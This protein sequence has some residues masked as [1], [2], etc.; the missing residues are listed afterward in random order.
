MSNINLIIDFGDEMQKS[1][2]LWCLTISISLPLNGAAQVGWGSWLTNLFYKAQNAVVAQYRRAPKTTAAVG[3]AGIAGLAG[4]V[5]AGN[6]L[7]KRYY[8]NK[9]ALM[10]AQQEKQ[11]LIEET[12][13]TRTPEEGKAVINEETLMQLQQEKQSLIGEILAARTP[14]EAEVVLQKVDQAFA[15]V[16]RSNVKK[17]RK[18]LF[19]RD[20]F[21]AIQ[22]AIDN[23]LRNAR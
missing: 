9:E 23:A 8:M 12:L 15:K 20:I 10:Q 11:P 22:Q 13:A 14:E 19:R 16:D 5:A 1:L 2:L 4:L 17:A 3:L 6:A 18:N 7:Y 21:N